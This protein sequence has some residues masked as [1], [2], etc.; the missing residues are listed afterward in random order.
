MLCCLFASE[1]ISM[2]TS[3]PDSFHCLHKNCNKDLSGAV[4]KCAIGCIQA[5]LTAALRPVV[6][7]GGAEYLQFRFQLTKNDNKYR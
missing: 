4:S 5:F 7:P 6:L 1:I 3:K 2:W